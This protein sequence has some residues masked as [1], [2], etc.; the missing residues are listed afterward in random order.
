MF[1]GDTAGLSTKE[2]NAHCKYFPVQR[3]LDDA[4]LLMMMSYKKSAR[5]LDSYFPTHSILMHSSNVFKIGMGLTNPQ[6]K[7]FANHQSCCSAARSHF[8][9][10]LLP[11]LVAGFSRKQ[12]SYEHKGGVLAAFV[13]GCAC[14]PVLPP[15]P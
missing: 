14:V 8:L 5:P 10:Q 12:S 13:C 9:S 7:R 15:H 11:V 1:S 2:M 4:S 6:T 3:T